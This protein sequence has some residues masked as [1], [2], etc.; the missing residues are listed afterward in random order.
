[1]APLP[2]NELGNI[3]QKYKNAKF[4]WAQEEHENQGAWN[5]LRPRVKNV[6][7]KYLGRSELLFDGRKPLAAPAGGTLKRHKQEAEE[8]LSR[9]FKG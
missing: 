3:I 6:F 7:R 8:I 5:Y 1:L 2:H 4:I 9:I